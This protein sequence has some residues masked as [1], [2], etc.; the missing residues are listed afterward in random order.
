[1]TRTP[2]WAVLFDLAVSIAVQAHRGQVDKAGAPYILHVLTVALAQDTMIGKIVGALHDVVEDTT[3]T[4]EQLDE[5]FPDEIVSRLR[6]LTRAQ[7]VQYMDYIRGILQTGDHIVIGVKLKDLKHNMDPARIPV[8]ED[9]GGGFRM[10]RYR[11]AYNL[12]SG[13]GV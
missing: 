13:L 3:W 2:N 11:K 12:L 8:G 7:G 10:G 9:E 5:I 1:M 6:P 4:F